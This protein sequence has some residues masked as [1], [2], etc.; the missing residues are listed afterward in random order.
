MAGKD[1]ARR[2]R[3][4]MVGGGLCVA[5]LIGYRVVSA[6]PA[7]EDEMDLASPPTVVAT[8]PQST[9]VP[10]SLHLLATGLLLVP[11]AQKFRLIPR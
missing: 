2:I 7:T 8:P 5:L 10:S 1:S 4:M 11:A 9:P 3:R 6:A